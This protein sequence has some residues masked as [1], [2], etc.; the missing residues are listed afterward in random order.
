MPSALC[1][2]PY[3]TPSNGARTVDLVA[4]ES[5]AHSY[6]PPAAVCALQIPARWLPGSS[7]AWCW[8]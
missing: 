6:I 2:L 4:L 8:A 3:S 1:R 5:T 7:C